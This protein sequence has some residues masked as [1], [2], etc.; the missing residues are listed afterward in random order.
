MHRIR[1]RRPWNCQPQPGRTVWRRWFG[2]PT[3][4]GPGDRLWLVFEN[5]P[6]CADVS[7]NGRLLETLGDE[8]FEV[9]R[10]LDARNELQVELHSSEPGT[11]TDDPP[12]LVFVEIHD[13]CE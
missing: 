8:R 12:F 9:T 11:P 4:L 3:G 7:L 5:L 6:P 2:R 1:L 10:K 13:A